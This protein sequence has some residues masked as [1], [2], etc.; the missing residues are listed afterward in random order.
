MATKTCVPKLRPTPAKG[1]TPPTPAVPISQS[2]QQAGY[3]L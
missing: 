2:K 1:Q 3:T